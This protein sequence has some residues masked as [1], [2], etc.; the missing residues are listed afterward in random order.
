MVARREHVREVERL[1]VGDA[2]RDREQVHVALRHTDVLGLSASETAGEMRVAEE[3]RIA[4]AVHGIL[5]ARR[6]GAVAERGELL[7]AV[8][9]LAAGDLERGDNALAG[10]DVRDVRADLFD[11]SH[12][13]CANVSHDRAVIRNE[14]THHDQGYRPSAASQSHRDRDAGR[15]RKWWYQSP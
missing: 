5:K 8:R 10:L 2:L 9:A 1:L 4:M 6:V 15:I 3:A 11:D 12:E 13:F 14:A 7:L